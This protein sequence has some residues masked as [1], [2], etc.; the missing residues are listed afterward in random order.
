MGK[1]INVLKYLFNVG[2]AEEVDL[3]V[4]NLKKK[5]GGA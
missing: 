5:F 2:T 1:W 4:V 3:W